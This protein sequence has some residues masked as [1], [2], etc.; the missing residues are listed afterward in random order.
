MIEEKI[1]YD[2][3]YTIINGKINKIYDNDKFVLLNSYKR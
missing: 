3:E 2:E 1:V